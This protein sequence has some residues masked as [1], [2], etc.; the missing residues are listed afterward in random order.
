MTGPVQMIGVPTRP[1]IT[2]D[3]IVPGLESWYSYSPGSFTVGTET[4][5]QFGVRLKLTTTQQL[6][7]EGTGRCQVKN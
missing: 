5:R 7:V 3:Q 2:W 1:R 4:S 6:I